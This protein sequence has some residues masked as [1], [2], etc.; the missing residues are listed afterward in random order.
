MKNRLFA[1]LGLA[2]FVFAASPAA[3]QEWRG[4]GRV[5]GFVVDEEGKPLE[6]VTVKAT[7]PSSANRGPEDTVSKK[8]GEWGVGGISS[9]TW[10]LD[11]VKEGYETRSISI[12]ISEVNRLRP[13]EIVMKKVVVVVDPNA[14]IK[15]K[16]TTAAELMNAGKFA[17]ARGMY[18][19]LA[20]EHPDVKEFKP[21]IARAYYGEGN[22][23][24]AFVLLREV[25]A[26]DPANVEVK[27]LLGTLL[28]EAGQAEEARAILASLEDAK[29]DDPTVLLNIGIGLIN[30]GKHDE[31][32]PWFDKAIVAFPE[33][34]DA[35]YYRGLANLATGK[36]DEAKADLTKFIAIAP[37]DAPE[38]ATAKAML[39]SIK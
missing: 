5:G 3:A 30:E 12:G 16:L 38:L 18:E 32:K 9:G 34:P 2:A 31:A 14:V 13:I 22:K 25:V 1:V 20:K 37:A 24:Q 33:R 27:M 8:D 19:E 15:E 39:D 35:Y 29:V 11:F 7:L 17:E 10:A 26:A 21:L 23:D 6:G 36:M 28:T 4:M